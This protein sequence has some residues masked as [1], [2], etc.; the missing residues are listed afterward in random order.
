[1]YAVRGER[2]PIPHWKRGFDTTRFTVTVLT[3][4][5]ASYPLV[6]NIME[7][8]RYENNI[9]IKGNLLLVQ[10]TDM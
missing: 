4:L 6:F 9:F 10:E 3:M 7:G 2:R 1:M 8:A 5:D